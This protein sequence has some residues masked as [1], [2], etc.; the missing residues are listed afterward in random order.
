M[1]QPVYGN[2]AEGIRELAIAAADTTAHILT[3][4]FSMR[5]QDSCG[6]QLV[7]V[8]AG[9]FVDWTSGD[10]VVGSTKTWTIANGGFTA[11]DVGRALVVTGSVSNDGTYTIASV[12]NGR[13]MVTGGTPTNETFTSSVRFFV[14]TTATALIGSWKIEV[15]NDY[16][17]ASS[18]ASYGQ[19]PNDGKWTDI[20]ASFSPDVVDSVTASIYDSQYVQ[21]DLTARDIRFTFTSD[22]TGAGTAMVLYFAKSWSN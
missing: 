11:G 13:V 6:V 12:T 10:A 15:S 19:S 7:T 14:R 4:S 17:P 16:V 9:R 5:N 8:R 2:D 1:A 3:P 21:A 22:G 18:G 20:T